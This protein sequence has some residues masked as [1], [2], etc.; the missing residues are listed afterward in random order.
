VT[1]SRILK[2]D[3]IAKNS[4]CFFVSENGV[5]VKNLILFF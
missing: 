2:L 1:F 5:V 3:R 4:I